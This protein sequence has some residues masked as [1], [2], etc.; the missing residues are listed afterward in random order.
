MNQRSSKI[1][2]MNSM[3]TH[4]LP[5]EIM[6]EILLFSKLRGDIIKEKILEEAAK[7]KARHHVEIKLNNNNPRQYVLK[8]K[9]IYDPLTQNL[10][11]TENLH[12]NSRSEL[13]NYISACGYK[14]EEQHYSQAYIYIPQNILIKEYLM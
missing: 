6:K 13:L 1:I 5:E 2:Q 12:W 8:T 3:L 4:K 11:S 14:V 7:K 10:I 9:K